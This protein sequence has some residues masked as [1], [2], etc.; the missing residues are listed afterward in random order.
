VKAALSILAVLAVIGLIGGVVAYSGLYNVAATRPH[1]RVVE[2]LLP[3]AMH[4]SV[5]RHA[6]GLAAPNLA[7]ER[8]VSEGMA[9]YE[10]MCEVCHGAPEGAASDVSERLYPR[11]PQFAEG[12]LDWTDEEL[13]WVTKHGIKMT[14][15]PA[16][17]GTHENEELWSIVAAV[18]R[19]P[20]LDS[21]A[22]RAATEP[23]VHAGLGH[24]HSNH[25]H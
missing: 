11:P 21:A 9:H 19:L 10:A 7:D 24:D 1:G 2:E 12:E 3:S 22:Y 16:F 17:G 5:V 15:M 18:Q 4:R 23:S 8:R 25:E 6:S 20:E 14:G 13:F